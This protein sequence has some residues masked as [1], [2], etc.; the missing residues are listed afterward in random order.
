MHIMA[1]RTVVLHVPGAQNIV[2]RAPVHAAR[3]ARDIIQR[4]VIP[5]EMHVQDKHSAV[6]QH[7][8]PVACSII[9]QPRT[10][11]GPVALVPDGP[12]TAA[13][14]NTVT[15]PVS[16]V[17]VHR[18]NCADMPAARLHGHQRQ[19]NILHSGQKRAHMYRAAV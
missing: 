5:A 18:D 8:V 13:V 16:A 14:M 1:L 3:S 9:V 11:A 7:I 2:R 19:Q 15:Q 12:A 6:V 17:I 10:V 4:V